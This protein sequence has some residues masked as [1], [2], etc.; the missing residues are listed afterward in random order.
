ML[1]DRMDND[2]YNDPHIPRVPILS[3]MRHYDF[4]MESQALTAEY[5]AS[6]DAVLVSTDHTSY[7]WEFICEHAQL[8]VDTRNACVNVTKNREKIVKA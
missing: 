1:T 7:D 4:Q 3:P 6:L 8:V 5:L 2:P